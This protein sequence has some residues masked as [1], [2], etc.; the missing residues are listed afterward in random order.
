VDRNTN[1][2][3]EVNPIPVPE[4]IRP[5]SRRAASAGSRPP[6]AGPVVEETQ[7]ASDPFAVHPDDIRSAQMSLSIGAY[8]MLAGR[9]EDL[10]QRPQIVEETQQEDTQSTFAPL[11]GSFPSS[12]HFDTRKIVSAVA[13]SPFFASSHKDVLDYRP[14]ADF[15][16]YDDSQQ[17]DSSMDAAR[18][19]KETTTSSSLY[20]SQA[21]KDKYT[22]KPP[23]P[24]S[25]SASKR[26][27]PADD[28]SHTLG[29]AHSYGPRDDMSSTFRQQ[30]P[31][32][33]DGGGRAALKGTLSSHSSSPG[34]V[35]DS[36]TN[37]R[38]QSTYQSTNNS[39]GKRK[40][41]R[42]SSYNTADPRL[43]ARN[44]AQAQKRKAEGQVVEGYEAERK[45]RLPIDI[46]VGGR[47]LRSS[48]QSASNSLSMFP[49]RSSGSR[50]SSQHGS[51]LPR[52]PS[53]MRTLAGASSRNTRSTKKMSKRKWRD[54][55][56]GETHAHS[57]R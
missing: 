50:E 18:A 45:K 26:L 52:G 43:V 4:V 17:A 5:D 56:S 27:R 40:A 32:I 25:N 37:N 24:L 33:G 14:T 36:Q 20:W 3:V 28:S 10:T 16:I 44:Q 8:D 9:E 51:S 30:T 54:Y 57:H 6:S 39:A 7:L 47:A 21:E 34:F 35:H 48:A 22:Y 29:F 49:P 41:S 15:T 11:Y 23:V 13:P 1:T 46:G 55:R 31:Q 53:H 2:L 42:N 19:L 12:Q 38:R